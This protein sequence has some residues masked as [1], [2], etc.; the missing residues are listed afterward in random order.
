MGES[1]AEN[2]SG[3]GA[4]MVHRN[5]MRALVTVALLAASSPPARADNAGPPMTKFGVRFTAT[6]AAQLAQFQALVRQVQKDKNADKL[7][8]SE[9]WVRM[10]P[11]DVRARFA[12]PT[13]K[14]RAD[15]R[16][17]R[18]QSAILI[19]TPEQQLGTKWDFYR[20]FEQIE[21]GDYEILGCER[22]S[23]SEAEVR[24]EPHG[25]PYGGLGP[26]IALVEAYGFSVVGV[27]ES[28]RYRTRAELLR[29]AQ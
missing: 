7:T 6:K 20:V 18:E 2:G 12:W 16:R 13:P 21:A 11:A 8:A 4:G 27:N 5:A 29:R 24:I 26:F 25:Y 22:T 10:V 9:K 19:G 28:G 15:W 14:E 3:M 1:G 23:E 17:R